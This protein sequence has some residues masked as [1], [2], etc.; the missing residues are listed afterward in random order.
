MGSI[1]GSICPICGALKVKD[2][3]GIYKCV[4]CNSTHKKLLDWLVVRGLDESDCRLV[5]SAIN[6]SEELRSISRAYRVRELEGFVKSSTR[7]L[8]DLLMDEMHLCK[9]SFARVVDLMVCGDELLS[10][11]SID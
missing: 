10:R 6:K 4:S 1:V 11:K 8:K 7:V 5:F 9:S 3:G 2:E